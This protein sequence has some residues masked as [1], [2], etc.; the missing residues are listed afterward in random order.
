LLKVT[1]FGITDSVIYGL[2][3]YLT[4]V[5]EWEE[6][7]DIASVNTMLALNAFCNPTI[8]KEAVAATLPS[9]LA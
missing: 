1:H 4:L 3:G 9:L 5:F 8:E 6:R 2:V 7:G